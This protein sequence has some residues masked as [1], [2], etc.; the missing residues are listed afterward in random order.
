MIGSLYFYN[1]DEEG[2]G[3]TM[4]S[5]ELDVTMKDKSGDSS[6]Q[7]CT[8]PDC[9]QSQPSSNSGSK[10]LCLQQDKITSGA[11]SGDSCG[12]KTGEESR[13]QT[14]ESPFK[15]VLPFYFCKF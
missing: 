15:S 12:I 7:T 13:T 10:C 1:D 9:K 3:S 8:N 5:D 2:E 6:R 4:E 11:E 14:P